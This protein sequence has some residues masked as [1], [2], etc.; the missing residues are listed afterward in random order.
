MLHASGIAETHLKVFMRQSHDRFAAVMTN[1]SI[2]KLFV[3]SPATKAEEKQI[4]MKQN[5]VE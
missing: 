4:I 3:S 1:L 5:R 2:K